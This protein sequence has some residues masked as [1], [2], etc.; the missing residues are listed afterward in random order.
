MR[1]IIRRWQLDYPNLS[2]YDNVFGLLIGADS[3]TVF[4]MYYDATHD[5]YNCCVFLEDS[6]DRSTF[7]LSMSEQDVFASL[8]VVL[9]IIQLASV[10][11]SWGKKAA[12]K[13]KMPT[14][15]SPSN[16][17]PAIDTPNTDKKMAALRSSTNKSP[18]RLSDNTRINSSASD[19]SVGELIKALSSMELSSEQDRKD[20]GS[21]DDDDGNGDYDDR[22]KTNK[23][24]KKQTQGPVQT[25]NTKSLA[26]NAP[27]GT[28]RRKKKQIPIENMF[29]VDDPELYV[30]PLGMFLVVANLTRHARVVVLYDGSGTKYLA[31][32]T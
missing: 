24:A 31:K 7:T 6:D 5:V 3:A 30:R 19:A 4:E 17:Q 18:S 23:S 27:K 11:A 10:Q 32:V 29:T 28:A 15:E 12:G 16:V 21:D 1:S 22:N 13:R 8:N 26:N 9:S 20:D 2:S 25:T 14:E